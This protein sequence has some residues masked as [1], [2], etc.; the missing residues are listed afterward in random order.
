MT[1]TI[2][3]NI[4]INGLSH[5]SKYKNIKIIDVPFV[6]PDH[7]NRLTC[8]D[9]V[10]LVHH[11][12]GMSYVGS[13]EQSFLYLHELN[14]LDRNNLRYMAITPCIRDEAQDETHFKSFL[15]C[16]LFSY[17]ENEYKDFLLYATSF[18]S[19]YMDVVIEKTLD[20]F[21]IIGHK[22]GIEL[23]SYGKRTVMINNHSLS[24]SYGTAFAEPRTSYVIKREKE[25]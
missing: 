13:A 14:Q 6:V 15:K 2:S 19:Q 21:D 16:E 7:I 9:W 12:E 4:I 20:G 10:Q 11:S 3:T 1:S 17:D 18:F 24:F 23:G 5:F 22:S 25:L 8:P